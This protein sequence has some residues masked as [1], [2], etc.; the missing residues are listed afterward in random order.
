MNDFPE[1]IPLA[2]AF[3]TYLGNGLECVLSETPT[4]PAEKPEDEV[5]TAQYVVRK[6]GLLLGVYTELY[7]GSV[8]AS[9]Q[10]RGQ[11]HGIAVRV[12]LDYSL[13]SGPVL[14]GPALSLEELAHLPG[15][16]L[17]RKDAFTSVP[18]P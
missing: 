17:A 10:Y 13:S 9:Q 16:K 11:L 2:P 1:S 15:S 7:V 12:L 6:N 4:T 3:C 14:E 5:R 8:L 18:F